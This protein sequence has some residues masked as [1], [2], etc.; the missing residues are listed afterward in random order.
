MIVHD[1]A[2]YSREWWELR[3]GIPTASR[4]GS[5]ITAK[6][7]KPSASRLALIAELLMEERF[8]KPS[9]YTEGDDDDVY[10]FDRDGTPW[11]KRGSEVEAE[12]RVWYQL[13]E[14]V[15]VTEVGF[16]MTDDG[17]AGCSPDGL[18]GEDGGLEIKCRSAKYHMRMILGYDEIAELPQVMGSM[19][20][21]GREWWDVLAY[22]P[23]LPARIDRFYR[24]EAWMKAWATAFKLY[25][26][27]RKEA[28]E[29]LARITDDV[30]RNDNRGDLWSGAVQVKP[31][32]P[33]AL[34]ID[35][36]EAYRENVE[37]CMAIGALD[38]ADYLAIV[39]DIRSEEWESVASMVSYVSRI[40]ESTHG[41]E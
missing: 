21:T 8:R 9:D 15:K 18:V 26:S 20:V 3:F 2:Q 37:R 7:A 31:T 29:R 30:V 22:C 39:N 6:T 14:G 33:G 10:G 32:R 1:V 12:A 24:D 28:E 25:K 27:D 4:F 11:M 36:L 17:D 41:T 23:G 13:S 16:C 38:A 5:I 19:W 35:A 34:S 40:L